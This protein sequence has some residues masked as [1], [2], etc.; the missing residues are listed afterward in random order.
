M[1]ENGAQSNS[2]GTVALAI[3]ATAV[4]ATTAVAAIIISSGR[5]SSTSAATPA[6][7][8]FCLTNSRR[9]SVEIRAVELLDGAFSYFAAGKGHKCKSPWSTGIPVERKVKVYE[10]LVGS[11]KFAKFDL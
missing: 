2:E 5:S 8:F 4:V 9:S 6:R 1:P 10:R 11:E 7:T 3:S